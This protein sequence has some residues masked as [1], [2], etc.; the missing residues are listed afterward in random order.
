[1][2]ANPPTPKVAPGNVPEPLYRLFTERVREY[3]MFFL[4]RS[5][6][7]SS[8]NDGAEIIHGYGPDEIVGKPFG[9]LYP[10]VEVANRRP[11]YELQVATMDGRFEDE[12]WRVR[13]DGSTF[14]ANEVTTAIKE[15]D[16]TLLGFGKIVRDLTERRHAEEALRDSEERYRLLTEAVRDYAI[17]ALD[18]KGRVVTWNAGAERIKGYTADEIVGRSFEAFYTEEDRARGHP[19]AELE[20]AS[21]HGRYEEEGWRVRKDGSRFRA[22]VTI[23]ALRTPDG[24]LR[25]F[26][27]V[28]RELPPP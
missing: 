7:V 24:K 6:N 4:D 27:K 20:K 11:Q 17:F 2:I 26:T 28:T 12:G 10:A 25:G 23:T 3:A 5:G 14:W 9:L 15:I 8:W 19:R 22:H 21:Q 1:M 13:K 16:G 18:P